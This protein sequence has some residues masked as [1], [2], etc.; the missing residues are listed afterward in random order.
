M[1][2]LGKQVGLEGPF[3]GVKRRD[4]AD[5][6]RESVIVRFVPDQYLY[7]VPLGNS[8]ILALLKEAYTSQNSATK[9]PQKL[10]HPKNNTFNQFLP[11]CYLEF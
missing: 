2:G 10:C 11:Q 3:K 7:I 4:V 9:C 5:H 6:R 1:R 8:V